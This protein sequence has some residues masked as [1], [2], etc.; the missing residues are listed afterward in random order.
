M[1]RILLT[2]AIAVL[3]MTGCGIDDAVQDGISQASEVAGQAREQIEDTTRNVQFCAAA[4]STAQAAEDQD[5]DA[6]IESGENLV[7]TA[8]EEIAA[9]AETVLEGAKAYR[10]G[11]QSAVQSEEFRDAAERLDTFARET[12]DPRS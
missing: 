4:L 5:W 10:D 3:A 9:D 11:D 2:I 7:E 1:R 12:C 8:P 6:A